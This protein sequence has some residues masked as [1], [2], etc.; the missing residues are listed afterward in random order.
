MAEVD[1][2][3]AG[4]GLAGLTAG[5]FA[6][7]CGHSTVVLAGV[8]PGGPLL[9]ISRI[10]DF[11]G[12]PGGVAGYELC[13]L[14]QEQ[15]MTAGAELR[16]T[17]LERLEWTDDGWRVGTADGD[18]TAGAVIFAAGSAPRVLGV[19][20]EERLTGRGISHC[21]SCDGPID[22]GRVVGVVGGGDAAVQEALELA[23]H[24]QEVILFHRGPQLSAQD[25][26]QRALQASGRIRVQ[27]ATAVEEVLGDA[28][29]AG[30]RSRDLAT[31]ETK[32]VELAA[33]FVYIGTV[34]RTDILRQHLRLDP[35]GRVPTDGSMRTQLR[36]LLAAGDV[37][38]ESSAQAVAA[39]GDGATAAIA[40][41][42]YLR[43]GAWRAD[44]PATVGSQQV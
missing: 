16:L 43:D 3:V 28:V 22:R 25:A 30:V 31:G 6:A 42:R 20:G 17:E 5:M 11:P 41:H 44:A 12:F 21:A 35:E 37:R 36:G 26:H 40:A 14:V 27:Y 33:L 29:V 24:A 9:S 18:I 38:S 10:D 13:P 7:R 4:G 32:D 34:P 8:V 15:A 39:A 23:G 1:I 2:V 19:P